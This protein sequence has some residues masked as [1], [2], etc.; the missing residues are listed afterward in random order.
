MGFGYRVTESTNKL[1]ELQAGELWV[2]EDDTVNK[3]G[4]LNV[5]LQSSGLNLQAM[6]R[7]SYGVHVRRIHKLLASFIRSLK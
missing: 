6:E 7:V 1:A 5:K 4:K 2:L 3:K